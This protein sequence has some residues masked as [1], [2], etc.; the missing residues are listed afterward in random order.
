ME[1]DVSAGTSEN[2]SDDNSD[3]ETTGWGC[4]QEGSKSTLIGLRGQIFGARSTL[5]VLFP[6]VQRVQLVVGMETKTKVTVQ[7]HDEQIYYL[8]CYYRTTN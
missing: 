4:K 8:Q 3:K 6:I 7:L 1:G 5:Y 2:D